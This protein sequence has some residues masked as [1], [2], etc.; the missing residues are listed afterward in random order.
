VTPELER[1]YQRRLR[2]YPKVWRAE[3]E[4][5]LL[6]TLDEAA[7]P[8]Q[9]QP[10]MRESKSL[11]GNGL[12]T[13][14]RSSNVDRPSALQQGLIWGSMAWLGVY[15]PLP[16]LWAWQRR[17]PSTNHAQP[18]SLAAIAVMV[19]FPIAVLRPSKKFFSLLGVLCTGGLLFDWLNAPTTP[20][21]VDRGGV[22]GSAM[23]V[24]PCVAAL[25]WSSRRLHHTSVRRSRLWLALPILGLVWLESFF[26]IVIICALVTII[27]GALGA[28]R[29]DPRGPIAAAFIVGTFYL[30]QYAF[31]LSSAYGTFA[32][33]GD[34]RSLLGLSFQLLVIPAAI[35]GPLVMIIRRH[36]RAVFT[37]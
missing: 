37:T 8:G 30:S 25:R 3:N 10:S 19:C 31:I 4:T 16:I 2:A 12:R 13:R 26:V 36:A 32:D 14:V 9:R 6:A 20:G 21:L 5:A 28:A 15:A 35:I 1:R 33:G 17:Y 29:F 7:R 23:V 18:F 11:I 22:V 24:L 27:V 34:Q